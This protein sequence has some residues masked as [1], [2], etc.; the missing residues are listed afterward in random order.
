MKYADKDH[1][2][3]MVFFDIDHG[4]EILV[5][6][7]EGN[8]LSVENGKPT[9]FNPFQLDPKPDNLTFLNEFMR[10]LLRGNGAP[11]SALDEAKLEEAINSVMSM[12]KPLR[13]LS[14]LMQNITEGNSAEERENSIP[15][16][17]AKWYGR[18]AY[19]WV[20]DNVEDKIDLESKRVIGIDGTDFLDNSI[21]KT[22]VAF[23][24]LHRVQANHRRPQRN[25]LHGR[26]LGLAKR[27]GFPKVCR[28]GI[29]DDP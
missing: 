23:Y 20:F 14:T 9:G 3:S 2:F 5:N 4:A 19:A 22:P 25:D 28:A 24:L 11:I 6:A 7:L 21:T 8:Y 1:K 15:R 17:L 10:L 26:I 16:R 18:G 12:D 27:R 13:R 29:K